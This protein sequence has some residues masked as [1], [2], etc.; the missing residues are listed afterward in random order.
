MR[1]ILM[2]VTKVLSTFWRSFCIFIVLL[3]SCD[4]CVEMTW[5]SAM[6]FLYFFHRCFHWLL[7]YCAIAMLSLVEIVAARANHSSLDCI[8]A[9]SRIE[10][11]RSVTFLMTRKREMM[12]LTLIRQAR[13][14]SHAC[15]IFCVQLLTWLR[16]VILS[17]SM[18][19]WT[20]S[21]L[22]YISAFRVSMLTLLN[23]SATWHRVWFCSVSSLRSLPDNSFS[24]SRWCQTDASNVYRKYVAYVAC[25]IHKTRLL[26]W[27]FS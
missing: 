4:L 21:E 7:W 18:F 5:T 6:R 11:F 15:L 24:F 3:N 8:F 9:P 20:C 14:S 22:V 23:I 13:I 2:W 17:C 16:N 12:R 1:S 10:L 25:N 27:F 26:C 19:R